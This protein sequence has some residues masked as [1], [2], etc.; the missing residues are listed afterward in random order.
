M[1]TT[2]LHGATRSGWVVTLL[3]AGPLDF[4]E[5][6]L[7]AVVLGR[8]VLA[9]DVA[10]ER[11]AVFPAALLLNVALARAVRVGAGGEA[12]AQ[13]VRRVMGLKPRVRRGAL[14]SARHAALARAPR[15][16]TQVDEDQP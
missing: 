15:G 11:A 8:Q 14:Q 13:R 7:G 16:G 1:A 3:L 9:A 10:T 5:E 2:A 6:A 12:G 4:L